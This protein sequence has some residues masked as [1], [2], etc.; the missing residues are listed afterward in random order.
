MTGTN[1]VVYFFFLILVQISITMFDVRS[2]VVGLEKKT[3]LIPSLYVFFSILNSVV[4]D[5]IN[6]YFQFFSSPDPKGH[7]RY[8][9][10]LASVVRPLSVH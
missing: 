5:P 6:C 10:H 2:K 9:H 8:C 4:V 1:F 3:Y 7:V